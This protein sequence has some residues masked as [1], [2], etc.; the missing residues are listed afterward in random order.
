M[1]R[2]VILCKYSFSKHSNTKVCGIE[3]YTIFQL[4]WYR[5][6]LLLLVSGLIEVDLGKFACIH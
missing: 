3:F 6:A 2:P 5:D 4:F 1:A